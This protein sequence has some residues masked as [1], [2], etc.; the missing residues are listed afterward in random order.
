MYIRT[1]DSTERPGYGL[2]VFLIGTAER[3]GGNQF[4]L[5]PFLCSH[6]PAL[7]P[8]HAEFATDKIKQ[9]LLVV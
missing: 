8:L 7:C 1:K 5:K 3:N 9:R 2:A 6:N 4:H